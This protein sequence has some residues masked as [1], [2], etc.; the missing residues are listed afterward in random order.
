MQVTAAHLGVMQ[1]FAPIEVLISMLLFYD[2]EVC[3]RGFHSCVTPPLFS[4]P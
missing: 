3:G 2:F 1:M 4:S